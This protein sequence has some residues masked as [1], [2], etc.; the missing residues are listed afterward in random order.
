MDV[1]G[2]L[3]GELPAVPPEDEAPLLPEL[4]ELPELPLELAPELPDP[5]LAPG[6]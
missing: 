1:L 2:L 3:E 6:P 5:A 4:P